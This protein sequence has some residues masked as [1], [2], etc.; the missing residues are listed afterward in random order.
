M[1]LRILV[2]RLQKHTTLTPEEREAL[3]G[4]HSVERTLSDGECVVYQSDRTSQCTIVLSG[5]LVRRKL[6]GSRNQIIA[7]CIPG[8]FTDLQ[9]LHLP[10]MDHDI[11]S[12]G[13]SRVALISHAALGRILDKFPRLAHLFWRDALIEAA[14]FREWVC[15]VGARDAIARVSHLIC[16]LAA[17]LEAV[18][19]LKDNE[20]HTPLTQ[21]N[22][23][24]ATGLSAVHVNRT[25]QELRRSGLISWE[26]REVTL[27]KRAELEALADFSGDYL[28]QRADGD[29]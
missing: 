4:M 16:E 5:L 19:L 27:I 13:S 22:I 7:I 25:V 3:A 12:I 8:D 15:I 14:L 29:D 20:F 17:R 24:D 23:A 18:G 10:V 9:T 28:H 6:V 11:A 1:P 26:N 2:D 21:Q